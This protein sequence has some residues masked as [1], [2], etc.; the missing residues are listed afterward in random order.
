[1]EASKLI[2]KTFSNSSST[3]A[4]SSR[5]NLQDLC[6]TCCLHNSNSN[7]SNSF[8]TN[9]TNNTSINISNNLKGKSGSQEVGSSF[10]SSRLRIRSGVFR[11]EVNP[12][13][14]TTRWRRNSR[15]P[16]RFRT[17]LRTTRLPNIL[18]SRSSSTRPTPLPF[19]Q[20]HR[21]LIP[22][23]PSCSIEYQVKITTQ[24][25]RAPGPC[26]SRESFK[27]LTRNAERTAMTRTIK[28][29]YCI[30]RKAETMPQ[31]AQPTGS[32]KTFLKILMMMN[33]TI[34]MSMKMTMMGTP[35]SRA[36]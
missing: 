6:Q 24:F 11:L 27:C 26:P 16:L 15:T 20:L 13:L 28:T 23:R 8:N 5:V 17:P 29:S 32:L 25:S 35:R 9:S 33:S 4:S 2:N 31:A 12:F 7:I 36:L 18:S 21:D 10:N 3:S 19:Q 30:T 14:L 22:I 34:K 1:M